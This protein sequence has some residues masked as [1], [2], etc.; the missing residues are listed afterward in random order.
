MSEIQCECG[1]F[2][3]EIKNFPQNTAGRCVCYCD[4]CQTYLHFLGKANLLD[5]AGGSEIIPVYPSDFK[6]LQGQEVLSCVR[7]S[8][9]GLFRW[10]TSCCK[11]PIGNVLP[12]FPWVGTLN[13]AYSIKE[14]NYLEK[15]LGNIKSRIYGKY[16]RGTPPKDTSQTMN[17]K[18]VKVVLPFVVKGFLT[19]K[20]KNSPFFEK[21]GVTP[22]T[23]PKVLTPEER[24]QIRGTI[25]FPKI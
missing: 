22:I 9:K 5:S 1:K 6:I 13:R 7:L 25:G 3:A 18:N 12:K 19:G 2:K 24:N 21:D 14:P 16:A 15:T 8:S 11:T 23:V 20:A 4:D 17:F 10:Y